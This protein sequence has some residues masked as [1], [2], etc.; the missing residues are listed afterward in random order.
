MCLSFLSHENLEFLLVGEYIFVDLTEGN[1]HTREV[2]D[3]FFTPSV[4]IQD[5]RLLC[6][7]PHN[8]VHEQKGLCVKSSPTP[9]AGGP[10]D[11]VYD[12]SVGYGTSFEPTNRKFCVKL[13]DFART[14]SPSTIKFCGEVVMPDLILPPPLSD[15]DSLALELTSSVGTVFELHL[16]NLVAGRAYSSRLIVEPV[17]LLGLPQPRG[18]YSEATNIAGEWL[19]GFSTTCPRTCRFDYC[20]LLNRT[21]EELP[22]LVPTVS[23]FETLI[24]SKELRVIN[25]RLTRIA[26]I[27]PRNVALMSKDSVGSVMAAGGPLVLLDGRTVQEWYDGADIFWTD[28]IMRVSRGIYTY[29]LHWARA[30][31]KTK[32]YI[33]TALGIQHQNCSLIVDKMV[34]RNAIEVVDKMRGLYRPIEIAEGRLHSTLESIATDP[35]VNANFE[36]NGYRIQCEVRYRYLTKEDERRLSWLR[37]QSKLTFFLALLA[38]VLATVSL[39]LSLVQWIAGW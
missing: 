30:E 10:D 32:E 38:T 29:L 26:L 27:L 20:H 33:T 31:P 28:D 14:R 7:S 13:P 15:S 36:W 24:C 2:Y 39:L 6:I 4:D 11:C 18:I 23:L 12:R 19:Q 21:K 37:K 16:S 25:P 22:D 35:E 17:E 3:I 1:I 8:L 5:L 9:G 34:E